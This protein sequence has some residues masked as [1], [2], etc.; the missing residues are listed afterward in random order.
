MT[1]RE[2][3]SPEGHWHVDCTGCGQRTFT[4]FYKREANGQ[5]H[6]HGAIRGLSPSDESNY[7]EATCLDGVYVYD[8]LLG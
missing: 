4:K 7:M 1:G 2:C 3:C 6:K 5:L 8:I